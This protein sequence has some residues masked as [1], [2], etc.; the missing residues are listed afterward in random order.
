MTGGRWRWHSR[1]AGKRPL[2]KIA[3]ISDKVLDGGRA[4]PYNAPHF[5]RERVGGAVEEREFG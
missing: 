2:K 1:S 3:V 4:P 5:D